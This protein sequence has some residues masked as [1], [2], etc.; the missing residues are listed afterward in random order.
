MNQT[1]F[2]DLPVKLPYAEREYVTWAP[3]LPHVS[4]FA[5]GH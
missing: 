1:G 3:F 5:D 2:K 4:V